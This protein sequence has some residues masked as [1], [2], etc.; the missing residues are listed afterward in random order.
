MSDY[1]FFSSLSPYQPYQLMK[2]PYEGHPDLEGADAAIASARTARQTHIA[3]ILSD[4]RSSAQPHELVMMTG[5][6]N[7]PAHYDWSDARYGTSS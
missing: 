7:E 5:D 3:A 4:L 1:L 2:I 6:F